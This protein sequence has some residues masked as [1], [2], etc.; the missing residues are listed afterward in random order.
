MADSIIHRLY[1][2]EINDLG[3]TRIRSATSSAAPMREPILQRPSALDLTQRAG[4][5]ILEVA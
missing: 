3:T 2:S 4:G 1:D 5:D